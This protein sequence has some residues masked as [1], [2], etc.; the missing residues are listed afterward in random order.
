MPNRDNY[1]AG[2]PGWVDLATADAA[3]AKEFYGGLFGWEW[4]DVPGPDGGVMYSTSSLAGRLVAGI[5]QITPEMGDI[6]PHPPIVNFLMSRKSPITPEMGDI[7]TVWSTYFIT[8]SADESHA[9]VLAAG[10]TEIMPP[11]DIMDTG[12]MAIAADDQGAPF[13]LWEPRSHRGMGVVLEPGAHSW[14][15]L[16]VPDL[17]RAARFY[18][19]VFG[20]GLEDAPYGDGPVYKLWMR[21]GGMVAGLMQLPSPEVHNCWNIYFGTADAADAAARTAE[22][23]GRVLRGPFP[24]PGGDVAVLQ[25]PQGGVFSVLQMR[26]WPAQ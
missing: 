24:T 10:G 23:G 7:P 12:R 21:E 22:L 14:T 17:E 18:G 2:T 8:D 25:D 3:G 26:E 5:S 4:E 19:A 20:W 16:I 6:P 11:C 15:E 9:A 13:G 1:P